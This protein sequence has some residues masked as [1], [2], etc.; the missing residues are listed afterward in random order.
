MQ[1]IFQIVLLSETGTGYIPGDFG[2][3][4][5]SGT[6]TGSLHRDRIPEEKICG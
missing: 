3:R 5:G 6:V 1:P 2:P 4:D